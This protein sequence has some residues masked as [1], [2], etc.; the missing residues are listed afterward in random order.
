VATTT[1]PDLLERDREL[2][3]VAALLDDLGA[4]RG[5][6]VVLE[7]PPGLGK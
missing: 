2:E 6:A 1:A 4:G 7:A 5:R 3:A